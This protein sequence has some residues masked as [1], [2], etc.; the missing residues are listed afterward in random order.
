LTEAKI[1]FASDAIH[2]AQ[3]PAAL[4]LNEIAVRDPLFAEEP[5][6]LLRLRE[7]WPLSFWLA[8][9]R[10]TELWG[11]DSRAN[12]LLLR[13]RADCVNAKLIAASAHGCVAVDR[14]WLVQ[15]GGRRPAAPARLERV[16]L[17]LPTLVMQGVRPA[18]ATL[19]RAMAGRPN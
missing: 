8:A 19:R 18:P 11:P 12:R 4:G 3:L 2:V 6:A 7:V 5:L 17:R 1:V 14:P 13:E 10:A 15:S 9:S 16:D